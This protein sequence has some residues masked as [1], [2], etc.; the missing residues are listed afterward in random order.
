M[1]EPIFIN[2]KD[3]RR[4]LEVIDFYEDEDADSSVVYLLHRALGSKKRIRG[5]YMLYPITEAEQEV[6]LDALS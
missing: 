3:W 2:Q 6:V 1:V 4:F 5:G